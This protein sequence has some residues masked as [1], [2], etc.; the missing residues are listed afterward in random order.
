MIVAAVKCKNYQDETALVVRSS[1][2]EEKF[3]IMEV[4]VV[5]SIV[6]VVIGVLAGSV[7]QPK[8]E[9]VDL[10]RDGRRAVCD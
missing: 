3:V 10:C 2:E 8:S 1:P 5:K 7:E 9:I 4:N 6:V